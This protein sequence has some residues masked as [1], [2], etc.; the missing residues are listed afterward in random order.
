MEDAGHPNLAITALE[1]E[2][3]IRAVGMR[4]R[5]KVT[6]QNYGTGHGPQSAVRL[7]RPTASRPAQ[8]D[9][10]TKFRR[11]ASQHK[12][13]DVNSN[14]GRA[15]TDIAVHLDADAVAADNHRFTIVD[16]PVE[17]PVL[18]ID[19]STPSSSTRT[20]LQD[21]M[22]RRRSR[23]HWASMRGG[24]SRRSTSRCPPVRWTISP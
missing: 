8:R 20:R 14:D 18:L 19:G 9:S 10:S 24:S 7:D 22:C 13:F 21:A 17:V 6:V 5:M 3:G 12:L 16:L 15:A 1:P 23:C 11:A 4:W 2:E